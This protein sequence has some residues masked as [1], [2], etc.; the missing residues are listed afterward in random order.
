[1]DEG[2]IERAGKLLSE[3]G[4]GRRAEC[5]FS[6]TTLAKVPSGAQASPGSVKR[7]ISGDWL[8]PFAWRAERAA[9]GLG[10]TRPGLSPQTVVW[11][12][13]PIRAFTNKPWNMTVHGD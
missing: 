4:F 1:M 11:S 9:V 2:R 12:L 3:T 6:N 13:R 8:A 7:G 5:V 10:F